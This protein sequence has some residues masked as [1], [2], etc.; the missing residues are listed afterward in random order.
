[1]FTNNIKYHVFYDQD[2]CFCHYTAQIIKKMDKFYYLSWDDFLL[3]GAKPE[4]LDSLLETTI[5]VWNSKT[6]EIWTRHR[7]FERIISVLP[8]GFIFSWIFLIPGLEKLFGYIYDW[9]SKNRSSMSKKL[10]LP[11]CGIIQKKYKK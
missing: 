7:G 5:V 9:I 4:N 1:M 8:F 2:C 6:N 11:A 3:E 10:G